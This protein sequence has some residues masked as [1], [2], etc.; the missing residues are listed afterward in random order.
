MLI[1]IIIFFYL[2]FDCDYNCITLSKKKWEIGSRSITLS[3]MSQPFAHILQ[4][5]L[6]QSQWLNSSYVE[7]C[8][9]FPKTI[10][11]IER[12]KKKREIKLQLDFNKNFQQLLNSIK[13]KFQLD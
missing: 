6:R 3:E 7:A 9:N 10:C 4:D 2:L 8:P 5:I 13:S 12:K 11:N 1:I